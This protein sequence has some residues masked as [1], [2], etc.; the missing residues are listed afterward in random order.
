MPIFNC[1]FTARINV[2]GTRA[3]VDRRFRVEANDQTEAVD[4]IVKEIGSDYGDYHDVN[5]TFGPTRGYRTAAYL[6][7]VMFAGIRKIFHDHH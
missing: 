2:K 6:D 5:F 7:E 1:H 3:K 4:L